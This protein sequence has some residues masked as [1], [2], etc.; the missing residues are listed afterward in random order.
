M[1]RLPATCDAEV[2]AG[3]AILDNDAEDTADELI[4]FGQT[5]DLSENGIGVILP[6]ASIDE[7][8]CTD[9]HRLTVLLHLPKGSCRL[10]V[11]PARCMAFEEGNTIRGYLLAGRI[12]S[13]DEQYGEYL[14]TLRQG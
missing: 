2:I 14:R 5:T 10:Q 6:S 13:R 11:V 12:A 4:F 3:L 9:V 8:F 1:P 7:R